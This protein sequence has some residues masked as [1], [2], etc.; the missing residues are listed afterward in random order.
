MRSFFLVF[1]CVGLCAGGAGA[2]AQPKVDTELNDLMAARTKAMIEAHQ[3]QVEIRQSRDN[4]AYTSPEIEALRKKLQSLQEALE[5]TQGE[6]QMK[7]EA[8]PQ[9]QAKI[10]KVDEAAKKIEE[11]NQKIEAKL[12]AE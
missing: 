7:V 6:I 12:G 9:V 8:L 1:V 2:Q 5:R 3:T 4:P 11:L 10:K